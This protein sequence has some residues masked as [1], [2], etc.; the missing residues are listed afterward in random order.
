MT[1]FKCA[2]K[3]RNE[4]LNPLAQIKCSFIV[5]DQF[6]IFIY[7]LNGKEITKVNCSLSHLVHM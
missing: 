1:S 4:S 2:L 7:F 6:F 5:V 3:I